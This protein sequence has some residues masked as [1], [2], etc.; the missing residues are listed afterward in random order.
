MAD[1]ARNEAAMGNADVEIVPG[2]SAPSAILPSLHM[3]AAPL[4]STS[5]KC[6][7]V[8]PS[9]LRR[10]VRSCT[11][12]ELLSI[13][14]YTVVDCAEIRAVQCFFRAEDWARRPIVRLAACVAVADFGLAALC[15]TGIHCSRDESAICCRRRRCPRC[16]CLSPS[17]PS[18]VRFVIEL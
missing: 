7:G 10:D 4:H 17:P 8:G 6:S 12:H 18:A 9:F 11:V 16:H 1:D 5:I 14:C 15:F 2:P 3:S 13:F